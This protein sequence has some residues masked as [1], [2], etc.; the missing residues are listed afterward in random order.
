MC[1]RSFGSLEAFFHF[2]S[3]TTCCS[4]RL[5]MNAWQELTRKHHYRHSFLGP[6]AKLLSLLCFSKDERINSCKYSSSVVSMESSKT[7]K[8]TQPRTLVCTVFPFHGFTFIRCSLTTN[9]FLFHLSSLKEHKYPKYP[10][11]S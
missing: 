6:L 8:A 9:F 10:K 2:Q 7:L 11:I 1:F 5:Y 4:S 3:K